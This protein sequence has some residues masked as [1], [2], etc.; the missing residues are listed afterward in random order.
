MKGLRFSRRLVG[1][2]LL[3]TV[4]AVCH[5]SQLPNHLQLQPIKGS[6]ANLTPTRSTARLTPSWLQATFLASSWETRTSLGGVTLQV[7]CSQAR[8]GAKKSKPLLFF[9]KCALGRPNKQGNAA[10]ASLEPIGRGRIGKPK[11]TVGTALNRRLGGLPRDTK[12]A[13]PIEQ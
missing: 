7:L 13:T 10:V 1:S 4:S 3:L 11:K 2:L 8:R 9:Q 12:T 5:P 6:K